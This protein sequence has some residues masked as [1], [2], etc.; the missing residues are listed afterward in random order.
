MTVGC[1]A[2]LRHPERAKRVEGSAPPLNVALQLIDAES[3][4]AP[5]SGA[6]DLERPRRGVRFDADLK[7]S[8][9][10]LWMERGPASPHR[11]RRRERF[12]ASSEFL[13][14]LRADLWPSQPA[15]PTDHTG[16]HDPALRALAP[17]WSPVAAH[18]P[19]PWSDLCVIT[20]DHRKCWW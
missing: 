19:P 11:S 18:P 8:A 6:E 15:R 1:P 7:S 10:E 9:F 4:E 17:P 14:G 2:S 12:S 13:R 3:A 5:P 20:V 16:R